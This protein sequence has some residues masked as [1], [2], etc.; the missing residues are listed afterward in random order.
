[1][2]VRGTE[3]LEFTSLFLHISNLMPFHR[4][5]CI[6]SFEKGKGRSDKFVVVFT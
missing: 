2:L 6:K 4:F 3:K 5:A 1:M